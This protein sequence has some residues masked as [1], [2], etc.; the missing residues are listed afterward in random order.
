VPLASYAALSWYGPAAAA[1]LASG[2]GS[3]AMSLRG[4]GGAAVAVTGVGV[5]TTLDATRLRGSP[6]E[7]TGVGSAALG[8]M[9]ARGRMAL[10]VRVNE[11]TQDDVAG[12]MGNLVIE[13]SYTLRD[14]MR[15][16]LAIA[17]GDATGLEG[18]SMAF[19]SLDG[20]KTRVAGTQ[21][22]GTRSITS[23]DVS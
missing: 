6:I 4:Y 23:R 18:T 17:Q 9:R 16:L 2:A 7:V 14:A 3:S 15:L 12:A 22:G 5:A 20:S 19:K 13:G 11:L 10:S 8:P 1:T 21:S